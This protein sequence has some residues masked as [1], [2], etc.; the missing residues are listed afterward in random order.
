MDR[1]RKCYKVIVVGKTKR[2]G[3]CVLA[4]I[5]S[6]ETRSWSSAQLAS[7]DDLIF[8]HKYEWI[9]D[10]YDE[11]LQ[12]I[13]RDPCA[14]DCAKGQLLELEGPNNRPW[15]KASVKSYA[16][17]KDRLFVLHEERY[18]HEDNS[19]GQ[20]YCILEYQGQKENPNW[21]KLKFTDVRNLKNLQV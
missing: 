20:Q 10:Y 5:F 12:E 17:V 2:R 3:G 6:S 15:N 14:Y 16:L 4:Q 8:G 21:A 7:A 11:Y 18:T 19:L 13:H 1:E 9:V